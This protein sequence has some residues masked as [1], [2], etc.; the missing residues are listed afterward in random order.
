VVQE[1]FIAREFFQV[2]E[3][4][5]AVAALGRTKCKEEAMGKKI[6]AGVLGGLAFFAWSSL[7]HTVLPLGTTGIKEIPGEQAAMAAMKANIPEG[8]LYLFPGLGLPANA[9]RA[10]QSAAMNERM[11][12]V[13]SGQSGLLVYHPAGV[14]GFGGML[15]TE[16]GTNMLQVFLAVLLLGQTSLTSFAARWRF[17]T[18][19]GILAAI[20]TNISYWN[21]YG[22]P[23]NYTLAYAC[24]IAMGFVFAGLVAAAMVKPEGAKSMATA[25]GK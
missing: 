19:A 4:T 5:A 6:L 7:A 21:W 24:T 13:A 25:G 2:D 3:R 22:F 23:G 8:G 20:S 9:T 15:M 18:V 14:P 16:L 17:I 12:K 11:Q 10:Q 1:N